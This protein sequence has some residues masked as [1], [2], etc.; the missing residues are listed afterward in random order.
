M[1]IVIAMIVAFVAGVM[2]GYASGYKAAEIDITGKCGDPDCEQ[3]FGDDV[4]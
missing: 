4:V 1:V 2:I 3:C